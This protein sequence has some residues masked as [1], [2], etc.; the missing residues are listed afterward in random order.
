MAEEIKPDP[1]QAPTHDAQ[2]ASEN[3]VAGEEQAPAIDVAADYEASKAFSVSA[4]D[5]TQEGAQ[6]AD[7]ATAPKFEVRE[8]EEKKS[9]AE[10]TSN[11]ADYREMAKDVNPRLK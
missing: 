8:P 10:P 6:A 1:Q 5:R 3:I 4:I 2:L 9:Q 7:A 11:P